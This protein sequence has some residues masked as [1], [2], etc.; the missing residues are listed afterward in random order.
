MIYEGSGV[1]ALQEDQG[2]ISSTHLF[3][4]DMFINSNSRGPKVPFLISM[5]SYMYIVHITHTDIDTYT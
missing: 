1:I 2:L 3:P 4:H 5:G